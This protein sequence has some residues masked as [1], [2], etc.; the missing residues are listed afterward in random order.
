MKTLWGN[1]D[2]Q[3]PKTY[4]TWANAHRAA[5]K[6]IGDQHIRVVIAATPDGRFFPVALG[7]D[8]AQAGLHH[9][10]CVA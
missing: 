7:Q 9:R 4:K 5:E 8:A 10:M 2:S 3:P 6:E 1:T